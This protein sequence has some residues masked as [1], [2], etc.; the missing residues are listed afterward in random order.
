MIGLIVNPRARRVARDPGLIDRLRSTLGDQGEVVATRDVAELRR[1][2]LEFRSR[3]CALV[4]TCGGDGT[5]LFVLTEMAGLY[6]GQAMPRLAILGG[7]TIN[8][9]AQNLGIRGA[10]E[11]VLARLL[12]RRSGGEP[13]RSKSMDLLR[14]DQRVGFI[15]GA[16]LPS[17]FLA[18]YYRGSGT[19]RSKAL[20]LIAKTLG[21]TLIGG[22][23][24]KDLLASLTADLVVDD[25]PMPATP[26]NI[27]LAT[28][29][30]DV[31]LGLR[32]GRR[33]G[34]RPGHFHALAMSA[35]RADLW[36]KLLPALRGRPFSDAVL[37]EPVRLL[38]IAFGRP[39]PYLL[40]GEIFSAARVRV[41]AGPRVQFE[42]A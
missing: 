32:V 28:T 9:V 30:R 31:A 39:E 37:D 12:Q 19:G 41:E 15:F 16:G 2:L 7:G 14:V 1:A 21:S 22:R 42:I 29:V 13:A 20:R 4:A 8:I 6:N 33:C 24:A 18:E 34:E 11:A 3:E 26:T 35:T 36:T 40:D 23:F 17:R 5:N 25:R 27:I 10:P 38:E